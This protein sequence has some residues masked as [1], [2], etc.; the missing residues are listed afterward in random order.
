MQGFT[1]RLLWVL[2]PAFL[3]AAL[4]EL[5]LFAVFDPRDLYVFGVP[6]DV[7]RMSAYTIGFFFLWVIASAASALT[8]FLQRSP[9]EI[10]RCPLAASDRPPGCPK[11][12]DEACAG[13][14]PVPGNEANLRRARP[15][16]R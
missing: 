3:V 2:W 10:N 5:A 16:G 13:G 4:A 7:D 12:A 6:V 9:F 15:T 1:Q 14:A 11:R 8:V